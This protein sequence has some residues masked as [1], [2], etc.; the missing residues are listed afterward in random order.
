MLKNVPVSKRIAYAAS[1]GVANIAEKYN[2]KFKEI[3]KFKA[4][5]VREKTG[6][7]LLR[8]KI[9]RNDIEVLVDPTMLISSNE[10]NN[11]IKKTKKKF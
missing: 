8:K 4:I 10:W 2:S 7:E 5:S 1:F 9:V 11:V 6:E 3:Q